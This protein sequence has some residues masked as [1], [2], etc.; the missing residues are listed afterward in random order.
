MY[1]FA[2]FA[3]VAVA[4]AAVLPNEP[5]P[6]IS[7]SS[8]VNPDG[9]YYNNYETGNGIVVQEQAVV[10]KSSKGKNADDVATSVTGTASWTAPDGTPIQLSW[11]AGED[12]AHFVGSHLPV[13]PPTPEIPL[14]IQR[15]LDWIAAHPYV[16][17]K[18]Q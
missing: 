2:L 10:V 6:I 15:S 8:E 1:G 5:V 12:G 16:E 13:A 14:A 9:S 11:T 3:I 17:P 7:Q 4:S 18:K